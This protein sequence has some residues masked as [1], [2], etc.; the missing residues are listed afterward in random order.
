MNCSPKPTAERGEADWLYEPEIRLLTAIGNTHWPLRLR[1]VR[2]ERA[3]TAHAVLRA[4]CSFFPPEGG[5]RSFYI[6]IPVL[7]P[8]SEREIQASVDAALDSIRKAV[9]AGA[10]DCGA[11]A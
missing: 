6:S 1:A 4:R 2:L 11:G 10:P 8:A 3:D 9:L 7:P 5:K